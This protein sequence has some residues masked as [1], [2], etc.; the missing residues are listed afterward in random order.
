MGLGE[1][2]RKALERLRNSTVL[3]KETVK[4]AVKELQRALIASD[5]EVKLVLELSKKIEREAFKDLHPS[6]NRKEHIIKTTYDLLS[7]LI[8]GEGKKAPEKP[9]KILLVGL[10]GQGKSTST[11]K[12]AKYYS[13]RG[14]KVGMICADSFRPAAFEQLKQLSEK[15]KIA[16]YG[17]PKEK[18]AAKIVKEGLQELKGFDLV[19]VDSAG[20][21]ALDK[22]L[23]KEIKEV[24]SV[25]KA[26]ERW[27]VL[28]ADVGQIAKKQAQAFHEAVGVNGVIITRMD[29]SAK[30]G[31]ALAACNETSAPVYFI[32]TGEKADDLQEFDSQRFLGR[33]MGYGDLQALLEKAEE[34]QEEEEL[35]LEELMKGEFNLDVFYKQLKAARKMGPLN[36]VMEMMGMGMQ[37]PK[38]Q[39]ELTEEKLDA[40]KYIMDSMTKE[41][42]LDPEKINK[43]RIERI[44][45]GS[46]KSEQDVR[47]LL[48]HFKQMKNVFKKFRKIDEKTMKKGMDMNKMMQMFGKKKKMKIR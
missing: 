22:E 34:V 29:G 36:K 7:E 20:R 42:K 32:G 9:K 40:F 6:I 21:S 5:V 16:F 35:D 24:N 43:S 1:Q 47:E 46:G 14:L 4:E 33:I 2:L 28:G 8:G 3:D 38:E 18:N 44:A 13:K 10:F 31:G 45:K 37:V 30:G 23:V 39:M 15:N 26:D 19:I 41:E 48:K 11:A 17:N 27:L 25:L 12:L